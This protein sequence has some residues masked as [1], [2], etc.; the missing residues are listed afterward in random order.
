MI[1][2][3]QENWWLF[4]LALLLFG[5]LFP[6]QYGYF[7]LVRIAVTFSF[8]FFSFQKYLSKKFILALIFLFGAILFNPIKKF[9][10]GRDLWNV[11]DIAFGLFLL[12]MILKASLFIKKEKPPINEDI[13]ETSNNSFSD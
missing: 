6:F 5:C 7:Q 3:K 2:E 1:N 9:A 12:I 4:F 8:A 10:L 13:S 11:V